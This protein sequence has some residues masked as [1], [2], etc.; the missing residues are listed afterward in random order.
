MPTKNRNS[1]VILGFE[2][3][4]SISQAAYEAAVARRN[5]GDVTGAW[6]ILA[7]AGDNY[8]LD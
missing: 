3:A 6:A 1:T 8:A 2:M 7:P 4:L 5:M